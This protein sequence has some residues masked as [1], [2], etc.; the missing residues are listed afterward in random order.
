M[1]RI[2]TQ[3]SPTERVKNLEREV[4]ELRA[5]LMSRTGYLLR[6]NGSPVGAVSAP[7]GTLFLRG[8][9]AASS[10]LYIKESGTGTSGWRAV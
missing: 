4:R 2:V 6:G 7:V 5:L 8:N 1:S 10:T 9:G 3:P